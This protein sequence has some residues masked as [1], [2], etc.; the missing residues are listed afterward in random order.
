MILLFYV[1]LYKYSATNF[2]YSSCMIYMT[3]HVQ[4]L[5]YFTNMVGTMWHVIRQNNFAHGSLDHAIKH[6]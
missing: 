6:G 5:K 4:L 1:I 3:F 2:E